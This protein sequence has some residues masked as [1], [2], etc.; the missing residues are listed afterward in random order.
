MNLL[1]NSRRERRKREHEDCLAGLAYCNMCGKEYTNAEIVT[2]ED[3]L[4]CP[5]CKEPE[6][7]TIYYLD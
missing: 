1:E 6:N 7:K 3:E 5:H 4:S 2:I